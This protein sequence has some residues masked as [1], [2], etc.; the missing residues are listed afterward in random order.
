MHSGVKQII[1]TGFVLIAGIGLSGKVVHADDMVTTKTVKF[2]PGKSSS[3]QKG[4]IKGR[5][6][7]RYEIAAKAGQTLAA[8]LKSRSTSLYFNVLNKRTNA[9]LEGEPSPREVTAWKGKLPEAGIYIVDVYLIRAVAR[10][11]KTAN[12]TLAL[13][14]KP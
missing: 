11:G 8:T 14:V 9:L 4:S 1:T 7:V 12:Y 13:T 5:D 6:S 3:T 10:R 2:A